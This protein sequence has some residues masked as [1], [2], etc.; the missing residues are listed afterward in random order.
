ML[1]SHTRLFL[2]ADIHFPSFPLRHGWLPVCIA[3]GAPDVHVLMENLL[4]KLK[5]LDYD[6]KFCSKFQLKPINR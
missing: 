2:L 1:T 5:L 4:D 3:G 6:G